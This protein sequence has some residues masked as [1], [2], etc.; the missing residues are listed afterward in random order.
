MFSLSFFSRGV[1]PSLIA[2]FP[3][4]GSG[5]AE[6]GTETDTGRA[7]QAATESAE[8]ASFDELAPWLLLVLATSI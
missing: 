7:S 4:A 2:S 3:A 6:P 8:P 1:C 5:V